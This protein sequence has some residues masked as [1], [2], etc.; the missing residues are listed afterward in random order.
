MAGR[1]DEL[2]FFPPVFHFFPTLGRIFFNPTVPTHIF[3]TVYVAWARRSVC[4][5][6]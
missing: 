5:S 4:I 3:P 2:I 6:D 1:A